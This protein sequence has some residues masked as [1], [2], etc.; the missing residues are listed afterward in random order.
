M[1]RESRREQ[2]VNRKR[3]HYVNETT[4]QFVCCILIETVT[5]SSAPVGSVGKSLQS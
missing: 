1:E 4:M 3:K 5:M 2:E